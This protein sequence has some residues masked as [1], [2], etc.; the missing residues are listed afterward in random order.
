[1]P[2]IFCHNKA[3]Y[4]AGRAKHDDNG[5]QFILGEAA[6][7]GKREKKCFVADKLHKSAGNRSLQS[8]ERFSKTERTS[9]GHQTKGC[10]CFCKVSDCGIQDLRKWETEQRP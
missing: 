3:G 8:G 2:H 5:N 1:M 9:H 10:G 6:A 4:C 7:D